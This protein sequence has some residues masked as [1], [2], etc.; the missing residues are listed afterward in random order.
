MTR[1]KLF[2]ILLIS[3]VVT[4]PWFFMDKRIT[5]IIGFPPWAF[6]VFCVTIVYAIIISV[7]IGRYW[8]LSAEEDE[9][10]E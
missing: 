10:K 4:I 7:F 8:S 5:H 6:Y 9:E 2:F 3:L 1:F